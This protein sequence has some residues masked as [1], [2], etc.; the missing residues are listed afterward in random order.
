MPTFK[1]EFPLRHQLPP[2]W[3]SILS[4]GLFLSSSQSNCVSKHVQISLNTCMLWWCMCTGGEASDVGA[5]HRRTTWANSWIIQSNWSTAK[6]SLLIHIPILFMI[7]SYSN[8][9]SNIYTIWNML[10]PVSYSQL[11]RQIVRLPSSSGICSI[12]ISSVTWSLS[13]CCDSDG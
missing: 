12:F 9:P 6:A 10:I 2:R 1:T 4:V 5:S 7:W 13:S 8:A 11:W 3:H